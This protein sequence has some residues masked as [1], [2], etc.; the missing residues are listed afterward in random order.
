MAQVSTTGLDVE[1]T[2]C[3]NQAFSS[4]VSLPWVMTIPH[5]RLRQPVAAALGQVLPGGMVHILAG[6][7]GDLFAHQNGVLQPVIQ[8]RN[9]DQQLLNFQLRGGIAGMVTGAG[10]GASN[11]APVPK[12]RFFRYFLLEALARP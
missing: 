7:L 4:R 12:P 5:I 2:C 1:S 3:K 10:C 9:S 6:G 8:A 11:G